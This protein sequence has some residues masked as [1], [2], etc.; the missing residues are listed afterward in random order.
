[1]ENLNLPWA[2]EVEL[3]WVE[4]GG[5]YCI[6]VDTSLYSPQAI[7]KTC[8]LF[9]DQ[10][11]LFVD[12]ENSETSEVKVYFSSSDENTD[13]RKIIGEFSNRLIWQE[14]R[15]KVWAE[16]QTVREIIVAQALTEGNILDRSGIEADYN[17]DP[18]G[19][20]R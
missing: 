1:M 2:K 16:T 15:Q 5:T 19:I 10:C 12:A 11:Y 18:L 6:S 7:L 4:T 9:L 17:A 20:A 3:P 14:V 13:L 8:Y